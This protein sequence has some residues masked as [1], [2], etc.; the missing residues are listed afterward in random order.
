MR[1]LESISPATKADLVFPRVLGG[2]PQS[3]FDVL[4]LFSFFQRFEPLTGMSSSPATMSPSIAMSRECSSSST[5]ALRP[6]ETRASSSASRGDH[7]AYPGH[8]A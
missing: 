2:D 5:V 3:R 7:L 8:L 6:P 1:I 4:G